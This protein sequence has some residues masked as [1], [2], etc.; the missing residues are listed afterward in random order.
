LDLLESK[1]YLDPEENLVRVDQL[2]QLVQLDPL[3]LGA[4]KV[5]EEVLEKEENQDHWDQ[6]GDKEIE[7]LQV[8]GVKLDQ[9]GQLALLEELV[10]LAH[11]VHLDHLVN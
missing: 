3:A 11:L 9:Q 7:V 2:V 4:C 6:L 5:L 1:V 10:L 8:Q